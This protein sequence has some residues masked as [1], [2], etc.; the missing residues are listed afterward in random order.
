MEEI[1]MAAISRAL[2]IAGISKDIPIAPDPAKKEITESTP[3]NSSTTLALRDM[4]TDKQINLI[5]KKCASL[6][7]ATEARKAYLRKAF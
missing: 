4:A 1:E 6:L 5:I 2:A 7:I 3:K